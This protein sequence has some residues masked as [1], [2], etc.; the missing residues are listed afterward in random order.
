M[1]SAAVAFFKKSYVFGKRN[2]SRLFV[3]AGRYGGSA[4]LPLVA[5]DVKAL[6]PI[7]SLAW[8]ICAIFATVSPSGKPTR[9][10]SIVGPFFSASS[11][12]EIVMLVVRVYWPAWNP[13]FRWRSRTRIRNTNGERMTPFCF[14]RSPVWAPVAP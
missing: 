8:T 4:Y 14:R 5:A 9:V 7:P 10:A 11:T 13:P 6:T 12:A 1:T 3:P 2:P